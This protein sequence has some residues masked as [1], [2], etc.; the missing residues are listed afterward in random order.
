MYVLCSG[1]CIGYHEDTPVKARR[2]CGH[3]A[4]SLP[5]IHEYNPSHPHA[6]AQHVTALADLNAKYS[7]ETYIV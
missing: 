1:E 3:V 5:P 2:M 7:S 6:Q 4:A